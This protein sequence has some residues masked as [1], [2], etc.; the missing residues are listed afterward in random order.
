MK[1]T[2]TMNIYKRKLIISHYL[3]IKFYCTS[4]QS[5]N[6]DYARF[7]IYYAVYTS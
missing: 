5:S 6:T 1:E 7:I 4:K 3:H 2:V